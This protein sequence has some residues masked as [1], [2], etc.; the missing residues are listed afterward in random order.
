MYYFQMHVLDISTMTTS[1]GIITNLY[2]QQ[3]IEMK[4]SAFAS[5]H[6][7]HLLT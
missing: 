6:K 2:F 1:C 3:K 5:L 7:P 4:M